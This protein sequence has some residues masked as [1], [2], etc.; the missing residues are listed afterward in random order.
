MIIKYF[1]LTDIGDVKKQYKILVKKYHPDINP[2]VD[3]RIIQDINKE[4]DYI[5]KNINTIFR[6]YNKHSASKK[7]SSCEIYP[8]RHFMNKAKAIFSIVIMNKHKPI[9]LLYKCLD[10]AKNKNYSLAQEHFDFIA[11]LL[12]YKKGWGYYKHKE[13][14][15]NKI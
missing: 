5:E 15:E 10:D 14:L 3:V 8:I 9:S 13:Y 6:G 7:T 11:E 2:N 1:K 4:K 12:G